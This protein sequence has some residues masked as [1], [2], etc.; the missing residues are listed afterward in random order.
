M[1]EFDIEGMIANGLPVPKSGGGMPFKHGVINPWRTINDFELFIFNNGEAKMAVDR[2]EIPC[3]DGSFLI[4]RPSTRHLS[5]CVSS[6]VF[7]RWMH[8]NW[9]TNGPLTNTIFISGPEAEVAVQKAEKP[10]FYPKGVAHGKIEDEGILAL[11]DSACAA[12]ARGTPQGRNSARA[13]FMELLLALLQKPEL[14]ASANAYAD[15]RIAFAAMSKLQKL[16]AQPK[17]KDKPLQKELQLKN[18]SYEHMERCFKRHFGMSPGSYLAGMRVA[19]AKDMLHE[20]ALSVG[21]I[22]DALGYDDAAYFSRLFAK[23]AGLAP[24]KFRHQSKRT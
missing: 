9:K 10:S 21:E 4:M 18:C 14:G 20:T 1:D 16:A 8:F 22:A 7:V 24:G 2:T 11:H 12:L 19:K 15:E 3:P 13:I 6:A 5:S 23:K 17:R